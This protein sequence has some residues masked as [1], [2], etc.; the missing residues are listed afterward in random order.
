LRFEVEGNTLHVY[1]SQRVIGDTKIEIFQGIQSTEGYKL[2]ELVTQTV[3]FEQLRPAVR[4][5]TN[6]AILPQAQNTP[7]SK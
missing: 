5:V 6:G 7:L 2:K 3:S 1:P 4:K